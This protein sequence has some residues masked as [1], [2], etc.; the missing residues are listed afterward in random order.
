[1]KKP[2]LITSVQD[3]RC[4]NA[5]CNSTS[6]N[7][8]Q[9]YGLEQTLRIE[10]DERKLYIDP[11]SDDGE[12]PP[13]VSAIAVKCNGCGLQ[14]VLNHHKMSYLKE[15]SDA[16]ASDP[17]DEAVS[18]ANTSPRAVH[19]ADVIQWSMPEGHYFLGD[20]CLVMDRNKEPGVPVGPLWKKFCQEL[21]EVEVDRVGRFCFSMS[22]LDGQIGYVCGVQTPGG[23]DTYHDQ[24]AAP[25]VVESGMI[26]LVS[27]ELW[28][29]GVSVPANGFVCYLDEDATLTYNFK[30][31]ILSL[32]S[33]KHC[34][35]IHLAADRHDNGDMV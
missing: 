3:L 12:A 34:I 23:D 13:E 8:K 4:P 20:P 35:D 9:R 19:D 2:S 15:V 30:S 5:C 10:Q 33:H 21:E 27:K 31:Q 26:G 14:F 17:D 1:M 11:R 29:P 16:M 32:D 28:Q 24:D 18:Y 22:N 25:Y 7:L 6:F